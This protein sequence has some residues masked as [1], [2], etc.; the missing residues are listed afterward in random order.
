MKGST[1][2]RKTLSART[3]EAFL[4]YALIS[5]FIIGF[6]IM[7]LIPIFRGIYLSFTNF[8]GFNYDH[9]KFVGTY[10]YTR[11]FSDSDAMYSMGR[12]L[13]IALITVPLLQVVTLGMS[14]LLYRPIKGV[15]I[16]RTIFYLP[17]L[18]PAVAVGMMW[19][20]IFNKNEGLLTEILSKLGL[21]PLDM[22]GY[23]LCTLALIIVLMWK[24]AGGGLLINIA[25]LKNVPVELYEAAEIDGASGF[26][27][28]IRITLPMISPTIFFN[29]VTCLIG[30]LQI[31]G[32]PVMLALGRNGIL[33]VPM[34]PNYVYLVHVYQQI[35][36]GQRFGY[37]LALLWVVV[38][39]I[40]ILTLMIFWTSKRWVYYEVAQDGGK[41]NG[42]K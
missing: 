3:K 14:M 15:G 27:K 12:T 23:D 22:M 30:M 19:S 34:R 39:V 37:G 32:E 41:K 35:F 36:V 11:V 33:N 21:P 4:F 42:G 1:Y 13:L 7:G 40:L 20:G 17:T 5:P 26:R 24:A 10:N 31:F 2:K 38:A 16:F 8:T 28:F 9:L 6:V 29:I 18:V 25:A